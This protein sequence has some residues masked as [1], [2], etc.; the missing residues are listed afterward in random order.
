MSRSRRTSFF[1]GTRLIGCACAL[2]GLSF[3]G[4]AK[5]E[6]IGVQFFNNGTSGSGNLAPSP[7]LQPAQMAGQLNDP[8]VGSTL[9][10]NWNAIGVAS[11]GTIAD[12]SLSSMALLDSSGSSNLLGATFAYQSGDTGGSH[13]GGVYN[14]EIPSSVA[15]PNGAGY[16]QSSLLGGTLAENSTSDS[17]VAEFSNLPT[18][19]YTYSI[20]AYTEM[21]GTTVARFQIGGSTAFPNPATAGAYAEGTPV[22]GS[23]NIGGYGTNPTTSTDQIYLIEQAGTESGSAINSANADY[24]FDGSTFVTAPVPYVSANTSVGT[25]TASNY[26]VWTSVVPDASGNIFL[27]W[28]KYNSI[29]GSDTATTIQGLSA[30]QLIATPVTS[31]P[32]PVGASVLA[33]GAFAVALRRRGRTTGNER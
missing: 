12:G 5:G 23:T 30:L 11:P 6:I 32:E 25:A 21:Y 29:T 22:S 19:G 33:I 15:N 9:Q 4:N 2:G 18:S 16:Y 8:N 7:A 14:T 3:I 17:G 13:K 24:D 20:V 28:N 27:T 26:A 1:R 31:V 10:A